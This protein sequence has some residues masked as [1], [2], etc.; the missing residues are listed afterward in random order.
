MPEAWSDLVS[1]K[2]GVIRSLSP[3]ARPSEE[4]EPPYLY[5]AVLSNFDFRTASRTDRTAAGKGMTEEDAKAAA[6]GEALERYCASHWDVRR[7]FVAPLAGVGMPALTP[8][9]CVLYADHQYERPDFGYRRW[10]PEDEI[11]WIV[12]TSLADGTPVALPASLCYMTFPP[13]LA[14]DLFAPATSNGLAAGSAT[15]SATMSGLCE[16]MERDALMITWMNRLPATELDL[17]ASDGTSAALRRHFARLGVDVRAFV[18][19]TDLPAT[20]VL[21]IAHEEADDRPATVVGMGCHPLPVSA[22]IK[23]LLELCQARPAEAA[24]YREH[25]PRGRLRRYEDVKTLDDHSAFAALPERYGEFDF[26]AKG[27]A[28]ARIDEIPSASTGDTVA[29]LESCARVL[30][31]LD[32]P[33]AYVD[34]TTDDVDPYPYRVVRVIAAGLQ[35]IHFGVGE[36][37]LGG[38]RLFE[39]PQRLGLRAEPAG[40]EDLNPCP[41]PMA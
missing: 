32:H 4:P 23:A 1:S 19:P 34:L 9:Q 40:I 10:M 2:V 41:H 36:E 27:G 17:E 21:A 11:T 26:L 22:L 31:E 28:T 29:D 39:L 13:P 24:R 30:L 5:T 20:V 35:P 25:P 8:A 15:V 6:I 18:L 37:R 12:G 38:R 33:C 14:E 7:A 16:V 3:Q